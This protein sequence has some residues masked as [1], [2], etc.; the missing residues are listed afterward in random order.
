M[1]VDQ[2]IPRFFLSH[3]NVGK[4]YC[5]FNNKTFEELVVYSNTVLFDVPCIIQS[6]AGG[7]RG[8]LTPFLNHIMEAKIMM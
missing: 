5:S 6:G 4:G 2:L 8:Q 3:T 1:K 7:Y